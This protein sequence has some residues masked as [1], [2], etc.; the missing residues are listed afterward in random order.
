MLLLMEPALEA[1]FVLRSI[2]NNRVL[3]EGRYGRPLTEGTNNRAE[4]LA[5][6]LAMEEI[7]IEHRK[8]IHL[9]IFSDSQTAV[10][11]LTG[12]WK[13]TSPELKQ[14]K[15]EIIELANQFQSV[16]IY[17]ASAVTDSGE[18]GKAIAMAD[19]LAKKAAQT[20]LAWKEVLDH[21]PEMF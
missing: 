20:Q 5:V 10:N 8:D 15:G 1:G 9:V 12:E 18:I 14:L 16:T 6:K 13:L 21:N 4:F 11:G 2:G 7:S 3:K 17:H 19:K